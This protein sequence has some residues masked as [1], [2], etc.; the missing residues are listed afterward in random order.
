MVYKPYLILFLILDWCAKYYEHS[1]FKGWEKVVGDTSQL[2]LPS[3]E[4][5]KISS[6]RVRHG[7]TIKLFNH[8]NYVELLD[9]LKNDKSDLKTYNDKVSSISCACQGMMEKLYYHYGLKTLIEICF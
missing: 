2:N 4:N 1:N 5:N 8:H 6:I 7:C 9:S 3:A